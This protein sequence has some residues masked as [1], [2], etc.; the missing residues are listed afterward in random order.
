MTLLL[1]IMAAA[2][3]QTYAN[4]VDIDYRY[5]FEQVNEGVSIAPAPIPSSCRSRAPTICS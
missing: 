5:N 3:P 1:S 4:P 2:T